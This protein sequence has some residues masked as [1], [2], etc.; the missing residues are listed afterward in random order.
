MSEMGQVERLLAARFAQPGE[1]GRI[2]LWRDATHEY[3]DD[4]ESMV[5]E[6][7]ANPALRD[8]TLLTLANDPFT[9]RYRMFGDG[10]ARSHKFLVYMPQPEPALADDWLLDL[11]LAYGPVFSADK[12]TMIATEILPDAPADVK[13]TWLEVMRRHPDF[14]KNA[15]RVDRLAAQLTNRDTEQDFM[16]K[17]VAVLLGLKDGNHRLQDIWA[18]LLTQYAAGKDDGIAQIERF[19]LGDFHWSGTRQIYHFELDRSAGPGATPTVKD[20]V[21]WLY[22]L[23]WNDFMPEGS[24]SHGGP[25]E[26]DDAAAYAN[27]KRD[28]GMWHSDITMRGTLRT[29]SEG[30]SQT[31]GMARVVQG[32]EVH[33]LAQRDVYEDLDEALIG[34]L[35]HELEGGSISD[36][37]VRDIVAERRRG[38][39]LWPGDERLRQGYDYVTAASALQATLRNCTKLLDTMESPSQGMELYASELY[40]A[41]QAYRHYV[42]A[43][44]QAESFDAPGLDRMMQGAYAA[45]Q[46]ALG[47]AW[48]QHVDTLAAWHFDGV[49]AQAGFFDREVAPR[50][51]SGKKL[52]VIISDALR[53]E[54]AQEL[55]QRMEE[56]NRYTTSLGMQYSVLPSY[57]QLGMAALLPHKQLALDPERD[58]YYYALVDGKSATGTE[59]RSRILGAVNGKAVKAQDVLSMTGDEAKELF[60]SCD[61]LYVYHNTIDSTGDETASEGN[62]FEACGNAVREL[63]A[64]VKKLA[65]GNATNFIVTADHGFLYQDAP[66]DA[67]QS[68]TQ[69]LSEKPQGEALYQTKNR[70][71]IGR[72]LAPARALTTF[73]TQQLGLANPA[74]DGIM[75]QVPNA[76][77]QLRSGGQLKRYVH[78]GAALPEIVVPV[79]HINK[80]RSAAGDARDVAFD[81][82]QRTDRLSSRQLTVEFY[83]KEPV[84]GKVRPRTVL[85]GL[86][87]STASGDK[88]ITNETPV[89]FDMTGEQ[90]SLR[91]TTATLML[92]SEA[93]RFNGSTVEL[94][95]RQVA[96]GS[97]T[98]IPLEQKALYRLELP[99][100]D[101][102]AGFFD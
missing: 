1:R 76:H 19:G 84:G 46:S 81:I 2:V 39:K 47:A 27:I 17:M 4:V 33:D 16:A 13:A 89:A 14:F 26:R 23:A 25:N 29:L 59:N 75:V 49:D 78:G 83:Q 44:K 74:S 52:I 72:N 6:G 79:L 37:A 12:L 21:L 86:W 9:V 102:N 64:L 55:A 80:G 18:R 63:I 45:Y 99:M 92:T 54:V 22:R 40:K 100:L 10:D 8:V 34:K 62:T 94:H 57:T 85:A 43:R 24:Q 95:L 30:V 5:G 90:P 93:D 82:L 3:A 41:D 87:G 91:H 36:D 28:W 77:K 35:L 101:D 67:T 68:Q 58:G 48:Q 98:P 38:E 61:V 31:L 96:S 65:S 42:M 53:Y 7:S 88:L 97:S 66:F 70:F 20:F 69:W 50:L 71:C 56:E 15:Q 32:M 11:E 51:E 60:K 73:T